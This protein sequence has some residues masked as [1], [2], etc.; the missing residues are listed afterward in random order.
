MQ[1][2]EDAKNRAIYLK[3]K[4]LTQSTERGIRQG[5][6]ML[7]KQLMKYT[8]DKMLEKPKHGRTYYFRKYKG[9]HS[10]FGPVN[11]KH[12]ASAPWEYPANRTGKLRKSLDFLVHGHK[13]LEFGAETFYA[14]YLE[15]GTKKG[16]APR[17]FLRDAINDN[18]GNARVYFEECIKR[19]LKK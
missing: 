9:N 16:M 7:G 15:L 18:A 5:Y 12:V 4:M 19:Y 17:K 2:K 8:S 11:N 1:I 10:K 6:F 14:K 3:I 13:Q